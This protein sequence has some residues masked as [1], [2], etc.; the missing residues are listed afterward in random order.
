M[1][2][3][4]D[5]GAQPIG[6]FDAAGARLRR[7]VPSAALHDYAAAYEGAGTTNRRWTFPRPRGHCARDGRTPG[8]PMAKFSLVAAL[9]VACLANGV[10]KALEARS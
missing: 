5:A 1:E 2:R 6:E 3:I 8:L 7:Y 9:R 10:H 4:L